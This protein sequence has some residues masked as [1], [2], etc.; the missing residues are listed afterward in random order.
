MFTNV[1]KREMVALGG[2]AT[3]WLIA[4]RY[5]APNYK[6]DDILTQ[7]PRVAAHSNLSRVISRMR[8]IDPDHVMIDQLVKVTEMVLDAADETSKCANVSESERMVVV[9]SRLVTRAQDTVAQIVQ[10]AK[11]D[12]RDDIV[13]M[14]VHAMDDE[15]PAFES[16]MESVLHNAMLDSF[17]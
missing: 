2:I 10:H 1:P 14:C 11:R 12:H 9:V 15:V 5:S 16:I 4:R 13:R 17:R 7:A 8:D 6:L 3:A